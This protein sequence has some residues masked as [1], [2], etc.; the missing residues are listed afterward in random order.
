MVEYLKYLNASDAKVLSALAERQ[1]FAADDVLLRE[2]E[3]HSALFLIR[4]GSVRV[5]RTHMD[6]RYEVSRFGAGQLFGEMAFVEGFSASADVLANEAVEVDVI[7]ASHVSKLSE[8]D[9]A[10]AGRFYH[11]LAEILSRRLRETTVKSAAE[12]SWGGTDPS[13]RGYT[14][15]PYVP[16]EADPWG[17]PNWD[18]GDDDF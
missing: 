13:T 2:G 1:T 7:A 17:G 15:D 9:P 16:N 4:S 3:D 8:Q 6:F 5:E 18:L 14:D 11:S 10:F 12:F